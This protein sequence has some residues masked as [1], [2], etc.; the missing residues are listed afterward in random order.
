MFICYLELFFRMFYY[1]DLVV[2][3]EQQLKKYFEV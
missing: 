2:Y 3:T 1:F